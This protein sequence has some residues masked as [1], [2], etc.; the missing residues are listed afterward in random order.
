MCA[1]ALNLAR[2]GRVVFGA[3]NDK[4]GGNGSILSLNRF[5]GDVPAYEVVGGVLANEAIKLLQSFY[6]HGNLKLPED[7]RQRR[8]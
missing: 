4:F 3:K 5:P 6:E 8:S 1:Y 2:V 7:K